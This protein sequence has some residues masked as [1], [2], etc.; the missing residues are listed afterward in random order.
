[1]NRSTYVA[2]NEQEERLKITTIINLSANW[3]TWFFEDPQATFSEQSVIENADDKVKAIQNLYQDL[4]AKQK[5]VVLSNQYLEHLLKTESPLTINVKFGQKIRDL[6]T[7]YYQLVH[8]INQSQSKSRITTL[9]NARIK[10]YQ[11]VQDVYAKAEHHEITFDQLVEAIK[12]ILKANGWK[13]PT[14]RR[15]R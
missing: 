3:P 7:I 12:M 5:I 14:K 4:V 10:I 1:M 6:R 15:H 13:D 8:K 11:Q 9:T 2:L